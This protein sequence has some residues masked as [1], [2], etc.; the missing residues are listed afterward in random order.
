MQSAWRRIEIPLQRMVEI[1]E[2]GRH[3]DRSLVIR[4]DGSPG[5]RHLR[6]AINRLLAQDQS[7]H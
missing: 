5:V 3:G 1:I 7:G 4:V 6:D 2:R